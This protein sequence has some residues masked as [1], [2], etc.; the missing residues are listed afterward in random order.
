MGRVSGLSLTYRF[1]PFIQKGAPAAVCSWG[2]GGQCDLGKTV[3]GPTS[4]WLL[5]TNDLEFLAIALFKIRVRQSLGKSSI[6]RRIC[7]DRSL[8]HL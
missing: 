2:A 8:H 4:L 3:G 5:R 6:E 7:C 1:D